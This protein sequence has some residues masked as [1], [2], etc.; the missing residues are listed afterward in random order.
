M[1]AKGQSV[2]VLK[3]VFSLLVATVWVLAEQKCRTGPETRAQEVGS[4]PQKP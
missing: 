1:L 3:D 2:S 4:S